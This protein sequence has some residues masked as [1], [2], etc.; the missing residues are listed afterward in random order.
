MSGIIIEKKNLSEEKCSGGKKNKVRLTG[1]ANTSA[2]GEKLEMF[3]TG[4][5][6]NP[7][8]FKNVKQLPC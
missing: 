2:T 1:M 7:R 4:K 6:K 8:C 3:V 5:S